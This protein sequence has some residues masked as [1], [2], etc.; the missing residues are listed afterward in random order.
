MSARGGQAMAVAGAA[1]APVSGSAPVGEDAAGPSNAGPASAAANSAP[2]G[3]SGRGGAGSGAAAGAPPALSGT[4]KALTA[5]ALALGTFMQVLDT[6]IANVSIPTIA[7]NLGVSSD[8][9][10]W[11]ITSFAVANGVS[12]PLTGWLMQRF[13][14]VRTFVMSVALFTV[15]SLLCGLAWSLPSLIMFRVLQGAV[16]GPMI[17]GSQ[18]LLMNV[19]GPQKRNTALMIWSLTTLVAP[20]AGP[21]LG[22][23]I[24]DN[25]IWPWIFLINVP[26]GAFCLFIS[27]TNLKNQETP[28]RK[29]PIDRVGMALLFIWVG[30]LQILLDEGKDL[31]W[32]NSV[33]IV[34]L[35]LVTVIAFV[36]W[37]IWELTEKHPIVDLSLF[38]SRNFTLGTV[39]LCLGYAALFGNIVLLPLWLQSYVGYTATWAGL[40]S[41]PS[42]VTAVLT[43]LV[44]GQLMR[45][46][47][48]RMLTAA[49]FTLYAIAYFMRASLTS[50]AN[51]FAFV[52]PQLVQGVAMGLFFVSL[53]A[54]IFDGLPPEKI[55]SASGLSNFLRITAGSFA[56]SL[57]TTFWDRRETL[58]QSRL[59]DAI[60]VYSP[61][62]QQTLQQLHSSGFSDQAA[63]G[64]MTQSMVG[65]SYLL[66]SL[67]LFYLSA[68]LSVV[69]IPLCFMVRR[70]RPTG[71]VVAAAD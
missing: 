31:D 7:G 68:W 55:P 21:V 64:V 47:D 32:F 29:L 30:A 5:L 6:S 62:Y 12:V 38:K 59:S 53:L 49:S 11:V 65:Q 44:M 67:D 63:A 10:T 52:A 17:P 48:P 9:G 66:S 60:T 46:Y 42:G 43:S 24:S 19:F 28:T 3:G 26:V 36:A 70:P 20:V 40:A 57:T 69:M 22:G 56:T 51:F 8:Q 4:A 37:L 25:Y 2:G 18:A 54:V 39:A 50:D 16:S 15:A 58:H 23:Y 41:A 33:V 13:G 34:A 27:W 45:R 1:A 61:T 71:H 14:V 35:A